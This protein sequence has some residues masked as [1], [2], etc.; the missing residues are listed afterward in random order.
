MANTGFSLPKALQDW[1]SKAFKPRAKHHCV[2]VPKQPRHFL[3]A[4]LRAE[5]NEVMAYVISEIIYLFE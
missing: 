4:D 3:I 5:A 2:A 1:K